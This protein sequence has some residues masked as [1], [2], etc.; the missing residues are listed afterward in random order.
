MGLNHEIEYSFICV[1]HTK[2]SCDRCFGVLKKKTNRT[3]LWSLYDIADAISNSGV[4][5]EAELVG[6]HQGEVRVKV[7]DWAIWLG[8]C[9]R[10]LDGILSYQHFRFSHKEPGVVKCFKNSHDKEPAF[11]KNILKITDPKSY[12]ECGP[13]EIVPEGFSDQRKEYL[14][15]EIRQFCKAGLEDLV[16]PCPTNK[17]AKV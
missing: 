15:N 3:E 16:A 11:V 4:D 6:N 17:K 5:N 13:N 12:L 14:Y 8:K 9:F 1:G 10:R 7:F 2:F